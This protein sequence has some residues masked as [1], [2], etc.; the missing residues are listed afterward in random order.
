MEYFKEDVSIANIFIV[1]YSSVDSLSTT[2]SITATIIIIKLSL[3]LFNHYNN[4]I[5]VNFLTCKMKHYCAKSSAQLPKHMYMHNINPP[6]LLLIISLHCCYK[7]R[8]PYDIV[9]V[10]KLKQ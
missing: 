10:C 1:Y 8:Q 6:Y 5:A 7:F 3:L 4:V 9:P 2:L